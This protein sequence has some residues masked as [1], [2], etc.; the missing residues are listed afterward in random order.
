VRREKDGAITVGEDAV[1]W[2]AGLAAAV[3]ACARLAA[4]LRVNDR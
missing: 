4:S 1:G 3:G 2:I